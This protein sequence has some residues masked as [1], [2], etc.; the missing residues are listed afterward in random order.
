[1]PSGKRTIALHELASNSTFTLESSFETVTE[2]FNV[3]LRHRCQVR[4]SSRIQTS[5]YHAYSGT[6]FGGY[7]AECKANLAG[8]FRHE[9][10]VVG[11]C[12]RV[13]KGNG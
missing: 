7:R 10:L 6:D 9:Y 13:D 12:I 2:A 1:M 11:I 8:K 3:T 5:I 4:V